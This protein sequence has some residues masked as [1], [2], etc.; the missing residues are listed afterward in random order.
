[1]TIPKIQQAFNGWESEIVLVKVSGSPDS[2]GILAE[3]E[4]QIIFKGVIQPLSMEQQKALPEGKRSWQNWQLHTRIEQSLTTGDK[5]IYLGK[6]YE[7]IARDDYSL[8]GY[9][10]YNLLKDYE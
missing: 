3:T 6:R 9:F 7:V 5:V 2:R 4:T 8:N 10:E 1:M